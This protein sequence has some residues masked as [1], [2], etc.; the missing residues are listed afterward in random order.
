MIILR[1]DD[2]RRTGKQLDCSYWKGILHTHVTNRLKDGT[3]LQDQTSTN[4]K[5]ADMNNSKAEK[6]EKTE[7]ILTECYPQKM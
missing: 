6:E 2:T 3:K 4:D 7:P 5:T 1:F